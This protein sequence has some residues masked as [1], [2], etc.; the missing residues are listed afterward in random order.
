[1]N[2]SVL[3]RL[4]SFSDTWILT[5]ILSAT[6]AALGVLCFAGCTTH[7]AVDC[8]AAPSK[9]FLTCGDVQRKIGG[10]NVTLILRTG[11]RL[12]ADNVS[13]T[14]DSITFRENESDRD[15]TLR[16]DCISTLETK[17]RASGGI[18]GFF[19]GGVAGYLA[20]YATVAPSSGGEM[21]GLAAFGRLVYAGA[22]ALGG[23][24]IGILRG[25]D[26]DYDFAHS[27]QDTSASPVSRVKP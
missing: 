26:R 27:A 25:Y 5:I 19:A 22:A 14:P 20:A 2:P 8:E 17:D 3:S 11:E 23:M 24:T 4:L 9:T 6:L 12:D 1:M 21:G 18:L 15:S 7:Y 16:T 10:Q 13:I